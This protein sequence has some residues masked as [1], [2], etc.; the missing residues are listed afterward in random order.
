MPAACLEL[1]RMANGFGISEKTLPS[2][3]TPSFIF[4]LEEGARTSDA[5][6]SRH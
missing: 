3:R 6:F 2:A 1:E 4:Q 5:A